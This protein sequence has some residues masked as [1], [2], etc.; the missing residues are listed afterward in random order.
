MLSGSLLREVSPLILLNASSLFG[1][2]I[3]H[4][5]FLHNQYLNVAAACF[6]FE[7]FTNVLT[8]KVIRSLLQKI[9]MSYK[10]NTEGTA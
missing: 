9:K 5:D 8:Q 7:L 6:G 4:R 10:Q 2:M 1:A 3:S